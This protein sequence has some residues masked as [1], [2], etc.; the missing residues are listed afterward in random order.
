MRIGNI[1]IYIYIFCLLRTSAVPNFSVTD[2]A[3]SFSVPAAVFTP[4]SKVFSSVV[5]I[6]DVADMEDLSFWKKVLSSAFPAYFFS[7]S[8]MKDITSW[9]V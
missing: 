6:F 7:S 9:D 8:D 3:A 5:A 2:S 4:D 1:Y